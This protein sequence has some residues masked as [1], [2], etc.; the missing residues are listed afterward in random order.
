MG[1]SALQEL[2]QRLMQHSSLL[3]SVRAICQTMCQPNQVPFQPKQSAVGQ[4][5]DHRSVLNHIHFHRSVQIKHVELAV[6]VWSFTKYLSYA[7]VQYGV[8]SGKGFQY[9]HRLFGFF[10]RVAVQHYRTKRLS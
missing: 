3:K 1:D 5:S 6:S 8:Q 10:L 7:E 4:T 2:Q 9:L